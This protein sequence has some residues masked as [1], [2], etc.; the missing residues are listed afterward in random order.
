[1]VRILNL[2]NAE[3]GMKG[4]NAPRTREYLLPNSNFVKMEKDPMR[5]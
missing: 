4:A 3:T 5:S 1:M 2:P